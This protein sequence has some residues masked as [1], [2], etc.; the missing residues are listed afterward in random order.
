M[1]KNTQTPD[2]NK[3][4]S[5][6]SRNIPK[7]LKALE[8][9]SWQAELIISGLIITG[10]LKFPNWLTN[11]GQKSL[12]ESSEIGFSFVNSMFLLLQTGANVL[13]F[14]FI[15]HFIMRTVWIALL[16]LNSVYP[17]GINPKSENGSGP[18][19]WK[20]EKEKYPNLS[21]YNQE[22]DKKCSVI[23]SMA[24]SIVINL[25]SFSVL[26]FILFLS[27]KALAS[28]FP[29]IKNYFLPFALTL[30]ILL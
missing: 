20:R 28:I 1:N 16:G 10:M 21:N 9:Q 23:F 4:D 7:W 6:T 19:V 13:I 3:L 18:E 8:A 15:V 24:C 22:L 14:F 25:L 12:L 27:F 30:Y 17:E 29:I 26:I 2:T 5:D 11:F